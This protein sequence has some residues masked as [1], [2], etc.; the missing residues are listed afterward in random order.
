MERILRSLPLGYFGGRVASLASVFSHQDKRRA[1][2]PARRGIELGVQR[3]NW[4][5]LE[6]LYMSRNGLEFDGLGR[7]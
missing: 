1:R 3:S 6:R 4:K 7:E 5:A 2:R